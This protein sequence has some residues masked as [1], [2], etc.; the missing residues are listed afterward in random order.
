MPRVEE[1][2]EARPPKGQAAI[3]ECDGEV[4]DIV[5]LNTEKVIRIRPDILRPKKAKAK[6]GRTKKNDSENELM[7][8]H[9][10]KNIG[11]WV[12]AG[13]KVK[14]GDQL[15]EGSLN[16][17]D[18]LRIAGK[19]ATQKY[20]MNEVKRVYEIAGEIIHDKHLEVIV[21][22]M[23]SRV[24]IVSSGS[25]DFISGEIID[26]GVYFEENTQLKKK[27]KEPA[28]AVQTIMGISKVALSSQSFLSAASFQET[29]RV[30]ITASLEGQVDKL[31]GLKENVIIGRLIPAGTGFREM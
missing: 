28:K 8:Y 2:F 23:F 4:E 15:C 17:K 9:I 26:K 31:R 11:L 13:D 6:R 20:I 27:R 30:L 19:E 21:K 5:E 25:S 10:P 14:T 12:K 7:E 29:A 18:L 16:L 24:K 22:Q 1:I 3:S